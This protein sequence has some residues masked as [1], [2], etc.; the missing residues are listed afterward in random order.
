MRTDAVTTYVVGDRLPWVPKT[1]FSLSSD[2]EWR[3]FNSATAFVGGTIAY[4]GGQRDNFVAG[5]ESQRRIPDYATIDLRAGADFGTFIVDAYVRNLTNTQGVSS[6][7]T[8]TDALTGANGLPNDAI[9]AALT[10]PRTI[11]VSL[12]AGF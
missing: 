12:T 1:S 7:A 6:I 5:G 3:I 10:R 4:T 8:F 9:R 2:Y 11:G